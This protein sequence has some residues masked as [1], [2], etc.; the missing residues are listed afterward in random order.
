LM[1]HSNQIREKRAVSSVTDD[2]VSYLH[3]VGV[4]LVSTGLALIVAYSILAPA[5][6][7]GTH[8]V[9]RFSDPWIARAETLLQGDHLYR[10]TYTTTPPLINVLLIP[11][12]FISG[13]FSHQNP[14]ATLVFMLY[15][16]LFNLATAL[17]LFL[18]DSD[19]DTGLSVALAFLL[20]PLTMGNAVLRRQDEAVLVFAFALV[21]FYLSRHQHWRASV[22]LSAG[23]LLKLT[24]GLLIPLALIHSRR[25]RYVFIP[26]LL[27]GLVMTPF[28]LSAG[29]RALFWD[30]NQRNTGHPF[31]FDGLNPLALWYSAQGGEPAQPLLIG[32]SALFVIGVAVT[33]LWIVRRPADIWEDLSLLLGVTLL[34]A[35]KLHCGYFALLILALSPVMQ[36]Y[37]ITGLCWLFGLLVLLADFANSPGKQ[38]LIALGLMLG[39]AVLL[40]LILKR[41]RQSPTIHQS[42]G[43][44]E[45]P[46]DEQAR[47]WIL[48]GILILTVTA[49]LL[50]LTLGLPRTQHYDVGAP[51]DTMVAGSLL[52]AENRDGQSFRW[53]QPDAQ[54][55]LPGAYIGQATLR[56]RLFRDAEVPEAATRLRLFS[57]TQLDLMFQSRAGWRVYTVMLP[58]GA[59]TSFG[60]TSIPLSLNNR[61]YVSYT[62]ETRER[63]MAVDWIEVTPLRT[64]VMP[65]G[66]GIFQAI[67]VC[68]GL[69]LVWGALYYLASTTGPVPI[70]A[71]I[72]RLLRLFGILLAFGLVLWSYFD[73]RS[74]QIA[75]S[76]HPP[77][78]IAAALLLVGLFILRSGFRKGSGAGQFFR[79]SRQ[80]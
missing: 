56:M 22:A 80:T 24:I 65:I 71:R 48:P 32:M 34:L 30:T 55:L 16:A 44:Q 47:P 28:L 17:I 68:S 50:T 37:R 40:V 20:N 25:W 74:F 59:I 57:S 23:L 77:M 1:A 73:L 45:Q 14:A 49:V 66:A 70:P 19:R 29:E 13:L 63:G 46:C 60:G 41:T 61:Q 69:A 31:Q 21:M 54:L 39:A 26:P 9:P 58:A 36:R 72:R 79:R 12:V 10:D 76:P 64:G 62:G 3:I 11:P 53:T 52:G 6:Y 43:H 38:Y 51:G 35:P 75:C 67:L 78:L 42:R 4:F 27:F 7:Y 8:I 2:R 33:L 5:G 15:F 18:Q